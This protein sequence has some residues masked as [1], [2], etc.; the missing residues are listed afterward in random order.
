VARHIGFGAPI[1]THT[2]PSAAGTSVSTRPSTARQR[3]DATGK[4]TLVCHQNSV[5]CN[6]FHTLV[7]LTMKYSQML[8]PSTVLRSGRSRSASAATR[9]RRAVQIQPTPAT[10]TQH[11]QTRRHRRRARRHVRPIRAALPSTTPFRSAGTV[12]CTRTKVA[13]CTSET[14]TATV[15]PAPGWLCALSVFQ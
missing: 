3:R 1:R 6:L 9:T 8:Q 4:T 5:N 15:R 2:T 7:Q 14:T 12:G 11:F 10:A 13:A